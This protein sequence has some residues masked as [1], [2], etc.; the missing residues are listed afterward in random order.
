MLHCHFLLGKYNH[1]TSA[2]FINIQ[3]DFVFRQRKINFFT[4]ANI[5]SSN[6]LPLHFISSQKLRGEQSVDIKA[7][8][9]IKNNRSVEPSREYFRYNEST[10][11]H[12]LSAQYRRNFLVITTINKNFHAED[13][14]KVFGEKKALR[15]S[16]VLFSANYEIKLKPKKKRE[17]KRLSEVR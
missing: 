8:D 9:S 14:P 10:W 1:L 3:S 4:R 2:L 12:Q 17:T 11:I 16:L 13:R 5:F 7:R 15:N 6:F